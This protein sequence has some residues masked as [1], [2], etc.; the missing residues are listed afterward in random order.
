MN[1][2]SVL[3]LSWPRRDDFAAEAQLRTTE[4]FSHAGKN[5][6]HHGATSGIGEVA[7]IELAKQGARIVFTARDKARAEATLEKLR[8]ANP[9]AGHVVHFGRSVA[10]LGNEARRR[11]RSR[12][13]PVSMF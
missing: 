6:R 12:D 11:K 3:F 1:G 8:R 5:R 2:R 7:A 10:A 4:P 13:E 9:A